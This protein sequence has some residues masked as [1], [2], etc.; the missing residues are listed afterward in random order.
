MSK[1]WVISEILRGA[2]MQAR[3]GVFNSQVLP[4]L[5]AA[6]ITPQNIADIR[7]GRAS[8]EDFGLGDF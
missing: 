7:S 8:E 3:E 5:E 4:R 6:G 1:E 2:R